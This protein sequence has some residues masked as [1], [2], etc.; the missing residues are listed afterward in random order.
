MRG[1]DRTIPGP[2][3]GLRLPSRAWAVLQAEN[4][5]T[6]DQLRAMAGRIDRLERIGPKTAR[7]IRD[8][9]ARVTPHKEQPSDKSQPSHSW[10]PSFA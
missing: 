4:I 5:T 6:L 10:S 9:L 8:E 2:I 3:D 7:T 1:S